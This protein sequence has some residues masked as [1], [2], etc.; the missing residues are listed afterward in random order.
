MEIVFVMKVGLEQIVMNV[1][2]IIIQK[3]FV[4]FYVVII[5]KHVK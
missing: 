4:I 1:I 3:E 5:V 2:L